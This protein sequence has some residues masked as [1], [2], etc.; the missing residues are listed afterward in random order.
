MIYVVFLAHFSFLLLGCLSPTPPHPP[1]PPNTHKN[2]ERDESEFERL[3]QLG[4]ILGLNQMEVATVHQGLAEQAYRSQAE[5]YMKEGSL[6]SDRAA[7][8]ES[9]RERMGL[10]KEVADKVVRGLQN[11]KLISSMQAAQKQGALSLDR[12]MELADAGV[13][14]ASTI[15]EDMRYAL[16]KGEITARISDG[17][18][19][20]DPERLLESLPAELKLDGAKAKRIAADMAR[21]RRRPTLVQAVSFLRQKKV[22]DAVKS[23]NNLAACAAAMP[24]SSPEKWDEQEEVQDLYALYASKE[25]SEAKQRRVQLVL[26]LADEEAATL[27]AA[28]ESGQVKPG[29]DAEEEEAALF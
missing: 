21:D 26:G 28:V 16:Y 3:A 9:L 2:T 17:T 7:A 22:A 10:P 19:A 29:Q 11:Q 8:L 15:K 20:F 5:Q 24:E 12:V 23:L 25:A 6:T 1:N 14:V 4:D 18:G 13:D 27:R